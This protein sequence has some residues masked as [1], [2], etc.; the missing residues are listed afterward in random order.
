MVTYQLTDVIITYYQLETS[1]R[2]EGHEKRTP[3]EDV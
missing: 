3:L 2:L 1:M